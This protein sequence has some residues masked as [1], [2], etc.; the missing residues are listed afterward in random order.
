MQSERR[1]NPDRSPDALEARL[2]GLPLPP[3]PADLEARLL[4]TIPATRLSPPRRW[5]VRV[6]LAGVLAAACLLAVL[7]WQGHEGKDPIANPANHD[8]AHQVTPR[9]PDNDARI[10]A[11]QESRRV[12]D[13]PQM[14]PFAWPLEET[15]PI[16]VVSSIPPDLLH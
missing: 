9:P 11:W 3:V 6:G 12:L 4:A 16:T 1:Q 13:D 8:S 5:A 10:A 7:A 15:S 2:R 14:P